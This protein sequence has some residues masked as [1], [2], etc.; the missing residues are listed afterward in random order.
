MAVFEDRFRIA[1]LR[2]ISIDSTGRYL[3]EYW[4][5]ATGHNQPIIEHPATG[6]SK[7]IADLG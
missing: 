3:A 1:D 5:R 7:R 4:M 6:C 2:R